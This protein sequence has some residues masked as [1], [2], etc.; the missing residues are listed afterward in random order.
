[1][2]RITHLVLQTSRS[3]TT[4]PAQLKG[5]GS[6]SC[7]TA[8]HCEETRRLRITEKGVQKD[9]LQAQFSLKLIPTERLPL[10]R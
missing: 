7:Y 3:S 5:C 1:M 2:I 6:A 9:V 4:T 8:S 10:N